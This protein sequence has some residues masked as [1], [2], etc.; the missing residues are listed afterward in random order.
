LP[1]SFGS[2][3]DIDGDKLVVAAPGAGNGQGT[4]GRVVVYRLDQEQWGSRVELVTSSQE[5]SFGESVAASGNRIV[6]GIPAICDKGDGIAGDIAVFASDGSLPEIALIDYS[7]DCYHIGRK[8]A[9]NGTLLAARA[10]ITLAGLI[11]IH[12]TS[13]EEVQFIQSPDVN[14]FR[15]LGG[16]FAMSADVLI[17]SAS[18][19]NRPDTIFVFRF[20]GFF[21]REEA[22]L[23]ASDAVEG[24]GFGSGLALVDDVAV[25]GD[26]VRDQVYVFRFDGAVWNEEQI[27]IADPGAGVRGSSSFGRVV[28]ANKD[29]I[30]VGSPLHVFRYDGTTWRGRPVPPPPGIE[31]IV[32]SPDVALDRGRIAVGF[33]TLGSEGG[34]VYALNDCGSG[35]IDT[36]DGRRAK[37]ILTVNGATGDGSRRVTV[38][39]GEPIEVFLDAA[40]R[41]P[42]AS[43]LL[44]VWAGAP[45]PDCHEVMLD[46]SRVGWAVK[47]TPFNP[48]MS[49]QP[50]LCV[51]PGGLPVEGCTVR[52][53]SGPMTVPW[54]APLRRQQGL[55]R[56]AIF[57][58]QAM[59]EDTRAGNPSGKSLS[60]A[61]VLSVE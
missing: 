12:R 15:G 19:V 8:V 32:E 61:V 57:T 53:R 29:L 4:L 20:D 56:A 59:V 44:W 27:L 40:P 50:K 5:D 18:G 33:P 22:R 36:A 58:L 10:S 46:E 2:A 54:P 49:P 30:V 51:T 24:P 21:Y 45:S 38:G 25:V 7:N 31:R 39:I 1:G 42:E 41:G 23:I 28:V 47:P 43:Y 3:L 13:G 6:V 9:T 16:N 60:N 52:L 55:S 37:E 48:G 26:S 35:T 17:A 34:A 14:E 11:H